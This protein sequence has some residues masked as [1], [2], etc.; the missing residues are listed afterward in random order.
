MNSISLASAAALSSLATPAPASIRG[1]KA[2]RDFEAHLLGSLLESMEKTYATLPGENA[3]PGAD[4]YNYI[5]TQA[6]AQALAEHGGFGIGDM[7]TRHLPAH[8]GK[9]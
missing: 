9:G 1:A 6:L 3:T 7:I 8:E 5:A 2:A 4:D